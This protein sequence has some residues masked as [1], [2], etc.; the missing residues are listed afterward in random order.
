MNLG[1]LQSDSSWNTIH[2]DRLGAVGNGRADDSKVFQEAIRMLPHG[3]TILIGNKAYNASIK[4]NNP[5][6]HI[7]G[8]G[9]KSEIRSAQTRV[10]TVLAP[11]IRISNLSIKGDGRNTYGVLILVRGMNCTIDSCKIYHGRGGVDT[12]NGKSPFVSQNLIIKNSHFYDLNGYAIHIRNPKST[13]TNKANAQILN[14]TIEE[15]HGGLNLDCV[16]GITFSGNTVASTRSSNIINNQDR[17]VGIADILIEKNIFSNGK[18]ESANCL[19]LQQ[20]SGLTVRDNQFLNGSGATVIMV[21]YSRKDFS[22]PINYNRD[23]VIRNNIIKFNGYRNP[24]LSYVGIKVLQS[25]NVSILNN[26]IDYLGDSFQL[27]KGQIHGILTSS[28]ENLIIYGNRINAPQSG[29]TSL[30]KSG[31]T[32]YSDNSNVF[33]DENIISNTQNDIVIRPNQEKVFTSSDYTFLTRT[34]KMDGSE[35]FKKEKGK[36]GSIIVNLQPEIKKSIGSQMIN[37]KEVILGKFRSQ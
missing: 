34:D 19:E 3:G 21:G 5:S 20:V 10:I 9:S 17:P 28:I 23:I 36:L 18:K 2:I 16:S 11:D 31:I 27:R 32:L 29:N 6:I 1:K 35:M 7:K 30:M 4:I 15:C 22:P 25:T 8:T 12:E 37:D 33:M 13:R 14:N 24:N 26:S